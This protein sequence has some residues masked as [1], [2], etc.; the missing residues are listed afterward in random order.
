MLKLESEFF[1]VSKDVQL[2]YSFVNK[3][4]AK[5][6]AKTVLLLNGFS[7]PLSDF[8]SLAA[9]LVDKDISVLLVDVRGS[10]KTKWQGSFEMKDLVS[11]LI[12]LVDH[13]G[14]SRL[15]IAGVSMGGMVA[16]CIAIENPSFL[17]SLTLVSTAPSQKYLV[18]PRSWPTE[19][20]AFLESV[21][22]YFA[23]DFAKKN[24]ILIKGFAK[25]I[26]MKIVE[27]ASTIQSSNQSGLV[28][29]R[30]MLADI[31]L[32][33]KLAK[34]LVPTQIIHG[35]ED[36]IIL[37]E[38]ANSLHKKIPNSTLYLDVG[39][40]HLYLAENLGLLAQRI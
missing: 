10:G 29:Q 25:S 36:R 2:H 24:R 33:D 21:E 18:G 40:G 35:C 14:I 32:E 15:H 13:L 4:A 12:L 38:A 7:R 30:K 5:D 19:E 17:A 27:E 26:R 34:V 6:A 11:D 1:N 28:E 37:P 16:Q 9:K 8:R 3:D 22:Q 23:P 20:K 39:V 31:E